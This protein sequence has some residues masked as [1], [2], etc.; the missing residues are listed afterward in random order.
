MT[1]SCNVIQISLIAQF[2]IEIKVLKA[3][4]ETNHSSQESGRSRDVQKADFI[5]EIP[6]DLHHIMRACTVD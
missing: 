5:I 1:K 4:I 2:T 6:H 3:A